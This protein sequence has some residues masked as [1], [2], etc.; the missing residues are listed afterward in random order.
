[1]YQESLGFKAN[2]LRAEGVDWDDVYTVSA[3]VAVLG[4]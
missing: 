3:Q 2:Q 4:R 1:M